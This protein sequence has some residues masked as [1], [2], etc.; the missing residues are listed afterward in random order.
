MG[1]M[2]SP[3]PG[4]PIDFK[5]S[6]PIHR[7][8]E[9]EDPIHQFIRNDLIRLKLEVEAQRKLLFKRLSLAIPML[10]LAMCYLIYSHNHPKDTVN[11][12]AEAK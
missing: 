2:S 11:I 12:E 1:A 3:G 8:V 6:E 9:P 5:Y 10:F 7:R 4:V